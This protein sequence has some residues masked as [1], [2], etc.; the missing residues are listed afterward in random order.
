[1][2]AN[3]TTSLFLMAF[4]RVCHG[5]FVKSS[6]SA[7]RLEM[8][9]PAHD[10]VLYERIKRALDVFA[11][12]T[13]LVLLSPLCCLIAVAV[14]LSSQGPIL[15]RATRVGRYN[16]AFTLYKFRSMVQNADSIGPAITGAADPRI[17]RIGRFLRRSKLDELPQLFN[18]LS[19][20]MSLVGPRPEVA[21]YT[22]LYSDEQRAVL[23]ALPGITSPASLYFRHEEKLLTQSDPEQLYIEHILATKLMLDLAYIQSA[24][25]TGDLIIIVKTILSVFHS[26]PL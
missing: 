20:E 3:R 1:M 24:S 8:T 17:T 21:R 9:T 5:M 7:K 11:S 4:D 18:V 15:H 26:E 19:G 16:K 22:T 2:R 25:I 6:N 23:N 14:K 13:G 12:L 10:R